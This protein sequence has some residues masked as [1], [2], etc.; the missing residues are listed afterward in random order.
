M[1]VFFLLYMGTVVGRKIKEIESFPL[2]LVAFAILAPI[3]NGVI[4]ILISKVCAT[5]PEKHDD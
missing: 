2:V 4:A 5:L 3:F 1:L